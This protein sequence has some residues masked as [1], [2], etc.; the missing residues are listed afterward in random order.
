MFSSH[1]LVSSIQISGSEDKGHI[2]P[3]GQE[4]LPL[5]T[6]ISGGKGQAGT[7]AQ[8]CAIFNIN[9]KLHLSVQGPAEH[10]IFSFGARDRKHIA[11]NSL[12]LGIITQD[13]SGFEDSPEWV[14]NLIHS[15]SWVSRIGPVHLL[16]D[17]I[18]NGEQDG[19]MAPGDATLGCLFA[20]SVGN[21]TTAQDVLREPA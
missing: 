1:G 15:F 16:F 21:L 7:V 10:L 8:R 18:V 4:P 9:V 5:A 19:A 3:S 2:A 14:L 12:V 20:S 13:Q 6:A 11:A 17:S